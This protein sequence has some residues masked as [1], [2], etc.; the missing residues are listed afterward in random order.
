VKNLVG[1]IDTKQAIANKGWLALA[2]AGI[3][4]IGSLM[5]WVTVT[6]AFGTVSRNGIDGDGKIT[7]LTALVFAAAFYFGTKAWHNVLAGV[8]AVAT[9]IVGIANVIDIYDNINSADLEG[10]GH[11]SLGVGMWVVLAGTLTMFTSLVSRH[12]RY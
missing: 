1:T 8:L 10:L 9:A 5:P 6:T 4:V 12:G 11:A 2:G 7:A 3:V